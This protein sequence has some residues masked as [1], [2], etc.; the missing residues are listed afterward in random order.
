MPIARLCED[1][2]NVREASAFYQEQF[3]Q[4]KKVQNSN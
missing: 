3:F 2:S 1:L 4:L